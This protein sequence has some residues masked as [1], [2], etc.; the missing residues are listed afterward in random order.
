MYPLT[1]RA[2]TILIGIVVAGVL[3]FVASAA[4]FF[5][6]REYLLRQ[7]ETGAVTQVLAA[8]RLASSALAQ[9]DESLGILSAS[10]QLLPGS[11]AALYQSGKWQISGIGFTNLDIPQSL[12]SQLENGL[13]ARQRATVGSEIS[14]LV[15]FPLPNH[16]DT[17]F[18]GVVPLNELE[19]SLEVL[20]TTLLVGSIFAAM[21]GG[22][23]GNWVSR[24]MM[25]PLRDFSSTA[26]EVSL[27]DLTKRVNEPREPD[28]ARIAQI[29]NEMTFSLQRRID[30][31]ARFGATVSHEL[32]SPLTVIRTAADI[33]ASMRSELPPRAQMS[34]DLLTQRVGAFEKI[35]NDLIEISRYQSGSVEV[36]LEELSVRQLV[37]TM[38]GRKGIDSRLVE[39]ED[40]T[41][42]VDV[43]RF[44]QIFEN[45]HKNA[46]LYAG[47]LD[48]IRGVRSESNYE[49]HFDDSGIGV[50]IDERD[51]I[52]EPFLRGEHHA[53]VPGSGLGLTITL[54]HAHS[55]GGE[56]IAGTSPTGGARFTLRLNV[57]ATQS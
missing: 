27:G 2:K 52:F 1:L 24:R 18:V 49:L 9:S 39:V 23:I 3:S 37:E 11:R 28:L 40:A 25:E 19:R 31:E 57:A 7:R 42:V 48:A 54:E 20:R 17:W 47:G 51:K 34:S 21:G 6:T 26:R 16:E 33:I 43:R 30:R 41:V 44:Q 56:L 45:I 46:E 29:F 13:P 50:K 15:G 4:T 32:R 38:A 12:L 35:L 14:I 22:V 53:A 5:L 10:A 55:M 8:A 36:N